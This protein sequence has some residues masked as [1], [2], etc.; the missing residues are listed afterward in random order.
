ML[1]TANLPDLEL[2]PA[3]PPPMLTFEIARP[4][5]EADWEADRRPAGAVLKQLR[6]SH[7]AV[8]R[9]L[10]QG[11]PPMEISAICGYDPS[12]ISVLQNDPS[13]R[14]LVRFYELRKDELLTDVNGRIQVLTLEAMEV[15]S[16]RITSEPETVSTRDL[17]EVIDSGL[18]RIGFGKTSRNVTVNV[19]ATAKD[20][21]ELR[22]AAGL[23][24]VISRKEFLANA[25]TQ[26]DHSEPL[27]GGV[28]NR[29][30]ANSPNEIEGKVREGN[31]V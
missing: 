25:P 11:V 17:R 8:A 13:F 20:L 30:P 26:S 31:D 10:A 22:S 16:D 19:S 18:D 24:P 7:H 9:M 15:L 3:D 1:N 12:R 29:R 14:E 6:A 23:P 2:I 4:L 27:L 5:N 21:A 28:Q